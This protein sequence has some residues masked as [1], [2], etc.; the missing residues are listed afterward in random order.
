M[1]VE[2]TGYEAV[3]INFFFYLIIDVSFGFTY[4]LEVFLQQIWT[5]E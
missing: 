4:S 3:F 1:Q 2:D 5:K